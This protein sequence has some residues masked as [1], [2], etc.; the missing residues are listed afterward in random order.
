[1]PFSL[2]GNLVSEGSKFLLKLESVQGSPSF[3]SVLDLT[4]LENE[5]FNQ[6]IK[7]LNQSVVRLKMVS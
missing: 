3:E 4:L 1:M 6:E 7:V 2:N 5:F